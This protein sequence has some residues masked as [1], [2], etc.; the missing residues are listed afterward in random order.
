[1][2][3]NGTLRDGTGRGDKRRAGQMKDISY[4]NLQ[5]TEIARLYYSVHPYSDKAGSGGHTITPLDS[6]SHSCSQVLSYITPSV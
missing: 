6:N 1:M 3:K 5:S 4:Y 2:D